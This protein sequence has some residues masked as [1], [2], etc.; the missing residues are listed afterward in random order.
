MRRTISSD[1]GASAIRRRPPPA[2]GDPGAPPTS[3]EFTHALRIVDVSGVLPVV[4]R[5][6]DRPTGRPRTLTVRGMFVAMQVNGLRQHHAAH[7]VQIAQVLSSMTSEQRASL[8]I[9]SWN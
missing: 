9:P 5:A 6:L 8:G 4:K 7:L 2:T 3:S 1:A